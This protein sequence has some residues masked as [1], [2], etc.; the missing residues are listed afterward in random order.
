MHLLTNLTATS[1]EQPDLVRR[2]IRQGADF[3]PVRGHFVRYCVTDA[4][5][6]IETG[7]NQ[8]LIPLAELQKLATAHN[9]GFAPPPPKSP[10]VPKT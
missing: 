6:L 2:G 7:K 1:T 3:E 10:A 4:G 5:L 8:A 9:P